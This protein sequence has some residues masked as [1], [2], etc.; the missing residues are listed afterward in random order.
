MIEI[1]LSLAIIAFA[2]VAIIGILPFGMNVQKDN[3]Q[4][5]IINQDA[6]VFMNAVRNGE[7]GLDDLTNYVMVIS[8]YARQYNFR[9]GGY[10]PGLWDI[11]SYTPTNS[12]P[13]A[14][15][16]ITNGNSILGLLSTPRFVPLQGGAIRSNHIVAFV[17]SLS[18]PASEKFP[19]NDSTVRQL[20]LSYRLQPEVAAFGTNNTYLPPPPAAGAGTNAL[21]AYT[22]YLAY[23]RTYSNN[24]H[25]VRLTFRWPLLPTGQGGGNRQVYRT[26]VSGP[27][28]NDLPGSP[29]YFFQPRTFVKGT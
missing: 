2:L 15:F 20:G 14:G 4:E 17:R 10:T 12:T 19:Q 5:T 24:L 21:T 22:N 13:F 1:A 18:G 7:R 11:R 8:N 6:T 26:L 3:R 28:T 9:P 29:F 25:D 16:P 27:L 23:F